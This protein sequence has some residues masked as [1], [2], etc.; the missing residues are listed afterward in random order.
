MITRTIK[1]ERLAATLCLELVQRSAWFE[2]TPLPCDEYE[3]KF[4][5]EHL[6]WFDAFQPDVPCEHCQN[7]RWE[8]E[9]CNG[10]NGCDCRGERVDMGACNVCGGT[11]MRRPDA[12]TRANIEA[13]QG[14]CFI[15]RGPTSGYWAGR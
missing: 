3:F 4:K 12:N 7:G 13:I 6:S 8:T 15:G 5:P 1:T 14:R 11:G 9:C 10:A 2:F